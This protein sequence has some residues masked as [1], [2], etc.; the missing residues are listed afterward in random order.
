[1]RGALAAAENRATP[2][3]RGNSG[4][5]I[6]RR[7]GQIELGAARLA[8]Q[9]DADRMKQRLALLP[10][11]CLTRAWPRRGTPRDRAGRVELLG[12]R[13]IT[14]ARRRRRHSAT[15]S[16]RQR[17][18]GRT[19]R[20]TAARSG[21]SSSRSTEPT[22]I[23]SNERLDELHRLVGAPRDVAARREV[24]QRLGGE[25]RR[26]RRLHVVA[27]HPRELLD[28]E[29]AGAVADVLDREPA[30]HLVAGSSSAS[31]PLASV[32]GDQ[33]MSAR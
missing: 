2:A 4:A 14:L 3:E 18:A 8:G 13:A 1:M 6:D 16:S 25:A 11:R 26:R 5:A 15:S 29:D 27:V 12:E 21:I 19:R 32:R 7:H 31:R 22:A 17:A 10:G 30:R 24:A 33:P 20:G 28:V 9:R 23:G